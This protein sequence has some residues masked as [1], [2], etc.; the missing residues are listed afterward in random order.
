MIEMDRVDFALFMELNSESLSRGYF[1]WTIF[2][3]AVKSNDIELIRGIFKEVRTNHPQISDIR[4]IESDNSGWTKPFII[5]S[6]GSRIFVDFIITDDSKIHSIPDRIVRIE[7]QSDKIIHDLQE[8]RD[9]LF[10][11]I[12]NDNYQFNLDIEEHYNGLTL[13]QFISC[14]IAGILALSLFRYIRFRQQRFFYNVYGL[15]QIIF[16]FE[17][18]EKYSAHHSR[19]VAKISVLL[20]SKC[21]IKGKKLNDLKVA[22]LLHDIGKISIPVEILNKKGA[23][24][25]DEFDV[26][27]QHV[28]HSAEIVEHFTEL[29]HL[30]DL[31]Y[32][33]HEKLDGTGY[34]EGLKGDQIPLAS[35]VLA[36]ADIFE[37]LTGKRPYRE[38]MEPEKAVALMETMSLDQSVIVILKNNLDS[39]CREIDQEKHRGT[40]SLKAC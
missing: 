18:T 27:K 24:D 35:R 4:F 2:Y 7:F 19:N 22:G 23:L 3:N 32:T 28:Q 33:H 1:Q 13:Y 36:I 37:A 31:I 25:R 30:R 6:R 11:S 14:L 38:P 26:V 40:S 5:Y 16:L 34:P 29:A 17:K 9:L 10:E 12:K 20:G 15:E 21:G 39:I 8:S